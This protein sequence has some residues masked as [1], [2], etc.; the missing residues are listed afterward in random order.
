MFKIVRDRNRQQDI[1]G[2]REEKAG[3]RMPRMVELGV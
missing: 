1:D 3:E 2:D